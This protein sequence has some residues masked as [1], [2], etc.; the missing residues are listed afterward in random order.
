M[1][2]PGW[3]IGTYTRVVYREGTILLYPGV[4]GCIP[5]ML[6]P[7]CTRRDTS[8]TRGV[9]GGI[10]LIPQGV[11]Q[12]GPYPR[13]YLRVDHTHGCTSGMSLTWVYL[14]HVSHLGVPQVCI[15]QGVPLRC[16]YTRVCL[17]GVLFPGV[18]GLCPLFPGCE[19]FMPVLTCFTLGLEPVSAPFSS[20][21][22]SIFVRFCTVLSRKYT[23][24]RPRT[25]VLIPF[26]RSGA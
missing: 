7:G 11:P 26:T 15:Y 23:L 1:Y 20:C 25:G 16:V 17:S 5:T 3:C 22:C 12:G 9:P 6:Y 13:V 2:I 8:H 4:Q 14:R 19:R 24:R 10:P 18:R 21:F